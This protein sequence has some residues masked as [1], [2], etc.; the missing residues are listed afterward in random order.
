MSATAD[1][2]A[3]RGETLEDALRQVREELGP[4][5]IVVKQREGIIGGVGGFFGKRCVEIE[6]EVPSAPAEADIWA[7]DSWTDSWPTPRVL[8]P[9]AAIDLYDTGEEPDQASVE[10]AAESW[11]WPMPY[12]SPTTSPL[13]L[14]LADEHDDRAVTAELEALD[15]LA[16]RSPLVRT[17]LEQAS[18]F[19]D[20]LAQAV[21]LVELA[22]LQAAATPEPVELEVLPEPAPEPAPLPVPVFDP[23]GMQRRLT[24]SGLDERLARE[25]V[26]QAESELRFFDPTEPFG[27]QVRTVLARRIR[28]ARAPRRS[29]RRVIALVG[30]SGSG[31]TLTAARL[32]YAHRTVAGRSVAALSLEP[33]REAFELA[34]HTKGLDVE[35]VVADESATLEQKLEKLSSAELL[36]VDTPAVDPQDEDRLRMLALLLELIG[37]D[38]THLLV[39]AA[40]GTT[41]VGLL[42][43][44]VA[45]VL[46]A[47]RLLLTHRDGPGGLG[48]AVSASIRSKLPI[49]F[50]ATGNAWGLRPADPYELAGLVVQ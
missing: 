17:L 40:L 41:D 44:T 3:Y 27:Q 15:D 35:L 45:P 47:D 13:P 39:P 16:Q 30:P 26:A 23:A 29:S 28:V 31:K 10:P 42:L 18:P 33:V 9:S 21:E 4:E 1:T 32:C 24:S 8:P 37:P 46:G 49:S 38:E 14:D 22:P 12:A 36:V 25:V 11:P 20:E 43:D 6:V 5:A 50:T 48:A 19:A 2:R 34:R 7:E